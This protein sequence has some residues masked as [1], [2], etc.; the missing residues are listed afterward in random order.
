MR[1]MNFARSPQARMQS[2]RYH[3]NFR[4]VGWRAGAVHRHRRASWRRSR[5]GLLGKSALMHPNAHHALL[6]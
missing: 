1:R 3:L 4:C 2:C 5:G 6:Q